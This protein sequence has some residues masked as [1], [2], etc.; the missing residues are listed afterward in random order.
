MHSTGVTLKAF[1]RDKERAYIRQV[2]E[3]HHGDKEATA[4]AL[5]ISLATF[6]RKYGDDYAV[7]ERS[8]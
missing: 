6:Y 7:P 3:Q 2:L 5:G 1:L 4:R 8:R